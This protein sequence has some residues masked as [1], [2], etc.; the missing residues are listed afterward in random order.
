MHDASILS[1]GYSS[2]YLDHLSRLSKEASQRLAGVPPFPV[3][4]A[5]A[6]V[7]HIGMMAPLMLFNTAALPTT[8]QVR[9][10]FGKEGDGNG[11]GEGEG[12]GEGDKKGVVEQQDTAL[13]ASEA[14]VAN[15]D[16]MFQPPANVKPVVKTPVVTPADVSAIR[17][18]KP[19]EAPITERVESASPFETRN[20]REGETLHPRSGVSRHRPGRARGVNGEGEGGGGGRPSA[21]VQAVVSKYE[22]LLSAWIEKHKVYPAEAFKRGLQGDVTLRLRI[23]R[24]GAVVLKTIEKTSGH[25]ELDKAVL[26]TATRANPMPVVPAEYPGGAQLEFLVPISFSLE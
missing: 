17:E 6:L 8:T 9:L 11:E 5:M 22:Q 1:V 12:T 3:M 10:A 18:P 23:N 13:A 19:V 25:P 2:A 16:R 21:R 7:L 24:Y 14:T 26:E 15:V 4:I 20:A